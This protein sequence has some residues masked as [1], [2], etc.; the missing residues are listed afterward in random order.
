MHPSLNYF[1]QNFGAVVYDLKKKHNVINNYAKINF[2]ATFSRGNTVN[3]K[4]NETMRE[5]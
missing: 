3:S 1:F 4:N 2:I 5:H